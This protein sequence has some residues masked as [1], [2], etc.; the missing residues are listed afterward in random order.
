MF[1]A[2][3]HRFNRQSPA[4][5]IANAI[6]EDGACIIT[7]F[8]SPSQITG[9]NADID[10]V[11]SSVVP[12]RP[13]VDSEILKEFHGKNTKHLSDLCNVSKTWREELVDDDVMHEICQ[14]GIAKEW[15]DYWLSTASLIEIGP[16]SAGQP[17]HT[18]GSQWWPFWEMSERSGNEMLLNFLVAVTDTTVENGATCVI[19]GSHTFDYSNLP[20]DTE[21]SPPSWKDADAIRVELQAGD[22][23]LAGGRIVHKGGANRTKDEK[24]RVLTA[25]VV[26]SAFTPEE[27]SA[28][29]VGDEIRQGLSERAR[30]FLGL[31]GRMYPKGSIGIWDTEKGF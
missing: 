14:K 17:L 3:F 9:L 23:L 19:P 8:Y 5:S 22:C 11:I 15:G 1:K 6:R 31:K 26:N 30:R 29:L 7:S 21:E 4:S 2:S 28:L 16:G 24:R 27:A 18:D 25:L 10:R 12:G 20:E 13:D